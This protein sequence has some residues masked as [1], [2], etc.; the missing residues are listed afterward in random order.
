MDWR[1]TLSGLGVCA[2][3]CNPLARAQ[4]P[5]PPAVP[6]PRVALVLS[7]GGARAFAHLGVLQALEE[8][9]IAVDLIVG[10]ECGALVGGL[11]A[12]GRTP[13]EIQTAL[14][15]PDWIAAIQNRRP[16]QTLSFSAKQE[17][18]SFLVDLPLGLG[19]SGLILPPGLYSGE[20]LRLEL[21]RLTLGTLG[22]RHFDDLPCAFRAV[23]TELEHGT[24]VTLDSGSLELAIE[25]SISTPVLWSPVR[26]N[27]RLLVS[28]AISDPLPVDVALAA[29]AETLIVIELGTPKMKDGQLNF[30]DVG[31]RVLQLAET[32]GL[33][34]ARASLRKGDLL[35]TP[36]L[37]GIDFTNFENA[38]SLVE[39]G[40]AAGLALHD[41]L[42]A[43]AL[44]PEAFAERQRARRA[45]QQRQPIVEHVRV[46]SDCALSEESVRA[47]M[48]VKAGEPLDPEAASAD[49]ARLYG[50]RIFQRVD[51]DLQPTEPGS[52]DL[53][54][55]TEE[56]PT[57]PLHWRTGLTGEASAGNDVNFV[58]GAGVRYS[59]VDDQGSEARVLA[60]V[61]NRLGLFMDY[62]K[63]LEPAGE[64]F[65]VPSA[66]WQQRP[67]RVEGEGGGQAQFSVE[68]MTL[69]L[70]VARE[71]GNDWEVRAGLV[72]NSGSSH[73]DIGVPVEKTAES[74]VE[75]GFR[76]GVTCDSMDDIAF[77]SSGSFLSAKWFLPVDS[78]AEG[79]DETAQVRADHA[80]P[81]GESSLVLGGEFSTV[82][83]TPQSVQ[84]FFPLGGFL[85]LSGLPSESISGPTVA[86]AHAV[87]F[88]P[89]QSR[90]LE[91]RALT[92]YGGASLEFGNAFA[93]LGDVSLPLLHPA[94][95]LFLGVD[96]FL[97]PAY[98]GYGLS[99]G[100]EH[101]VFM[102]LGRVF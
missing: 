4:D 14:L 47:R 17:D 64:W 80:I 27:D 75:G 93:E 19:T 91:S 10:S 45:S 31:T 74:F 65:L 71:F 55:H 96:T 39:R 42:A 83:G 37:Q 15:A 35:C 28:G 46:D 43:L 84:S 33:A 34:A 23:A 6:R 38:A 59:P 86:L 48:T 101:S 92:W 16:R 99:E 95:S 5:A 62:R 89:L 69:G 87:Y 73:P 3:A 70:D 60:E 68:Q 88:L 102:V 26:V 21:A 97:G 53:V 67:V 49:L 25:A 57:A 12:A 63:A 56:L 81:L 54:V 79:Q 77:P 51:F 50:L 44:T 40:H 22:T 61:G 18:R 2:L 72:Y 76:L 66:N 8:E 9:H 29:G 36:D 41:R 78:F 58:I 32:P 30:I 82:I 90:G 98:L 11:Y 13:G 100:G 20:R 94:G 7:S 1:R 24:V 85:R 52:A